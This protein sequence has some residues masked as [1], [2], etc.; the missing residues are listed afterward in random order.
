MNYPPISLQQTLL[1]VRLFT[2][3]IFDAL[4]LNGL[5]KTQFVLSSSQLTAGNYVGALR[6]QRNV[7]MRRN[8]RDSWKAEVL[9]FLV[10]ID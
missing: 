6:S 8:E 5:S 4:T 3:L 9:I 2:D 10:P 1:E 7:G